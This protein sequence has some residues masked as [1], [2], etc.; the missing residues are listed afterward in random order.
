MSIHFDGTHSLKFIYYPKN[1]SSIFHSCLHSLYI[2]RFTEPRL[3]KPL[4]NL[5]QLNES[6]SNAIPKLRYFDEI[7]TILNFCVVIMIP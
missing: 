1:E 4:N 3:E 7:T 2:A 5:N 6:L